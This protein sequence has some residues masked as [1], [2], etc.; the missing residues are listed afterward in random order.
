MKEAADD[1]LRTTGSRHQ[2]QHL[3]EVPT[4][5]HTLTHRSYDHMHKTSARP[6][7]QSIQNLNIGEEF[8]KYCL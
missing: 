3:P 6:Q 1:F 8:K 2:Q 5:L 4:Y 7:D